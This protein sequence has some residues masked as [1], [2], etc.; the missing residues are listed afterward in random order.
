MYTNAGPGVGANAVTSYNGTTGA[1]IG[2]FVQQ[3][4]IGLLHGMVFNGGYLYVGSQRTNEVLQYN[5]TTG[6][7]V[8]VFLSNVSGGPNNLAFGPRAY[9]LKPARSMVSNGQ[10]LA[11]PAFLGLRSCIQ[12][13]PSTIAA[14]PASVCAGD[15]LSA[16][17]AP[18]CLR[19]KSA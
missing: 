5:A 17:T 12:W 8:G 6:A 3:G 13:R 14:K 11:R 2:L 1:L 10:K 19:C 16:I 9:A 4:Q 15:L 7:Y 18:C